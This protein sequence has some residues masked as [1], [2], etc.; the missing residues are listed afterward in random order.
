MIDM[1]NREVYINTVGKCI[2]WLEEDVY[3]IL[4]DTYLYATDGE[5]FE[6]LSETSR[7]ACKIVENHANPVLGALS[8][9]PVIIV[10]ALVIT[11]VVL[12]V[13]I[14]KHNKANKKIPTERYM[15]SSFVV[16][17]KNVIYK[18]CRKEVVRGYYAENKSS[19]GGGS[20]TSSRGVSHG[21]GGHKF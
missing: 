12:V 19:G 6:C 14:T 10:I 15:G 4:D 17:D 18:G 21:G 7:Q 20:H 9:S 1:D 13:L 2:N 11:V 8:P 16:N 3:D 5:Y